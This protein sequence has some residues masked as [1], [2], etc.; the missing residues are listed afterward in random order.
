V[1]LT[2]LESF[3][4]DICELQFELLRNFIDKHSYPSHPILVL[5]DLNTDGRPMFQQD[6]NSQ[7]QRM[8][9]TFRR[10]R[11]DVIDVWPHL[12]TSPGGT[13]RPTEEGGERLDYVIVLNPRVGGFFE[14]TNITVNELADPKVRSLSDHAAIETELRWI[15]R[16]PCR[17]TM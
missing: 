5:G 8:M 6:V 16:R 1:F 17:Q 7:Y 4:S 2:H 14:A 13:N 11:P 10:I 15:R 3:D 12:H 9:S